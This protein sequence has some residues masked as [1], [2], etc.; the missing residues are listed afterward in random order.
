MVPIRIFAVLSSIGARL[1]V[2]SLGTALNGRAGTMVRF[3]LVSTRR[4]DIDKLDWEKS[5]VA[6]SLNVEL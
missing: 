1:N 4:L 5:V 2:G 6:R 3:V